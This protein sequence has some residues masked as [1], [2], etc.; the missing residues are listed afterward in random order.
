MIDKSKESP[1]SLEER[2]KIL[3][4]N[5]NANLSQTEWD[6]MEKEEK[7]RSSAWERENDRA[8]YSTQYTKRFY[9]TDQK[10]IKSLRSVG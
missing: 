1:L 7:K 8:N 6:E 2:R 5:Y 9:A 10:S 4:E 3:Y